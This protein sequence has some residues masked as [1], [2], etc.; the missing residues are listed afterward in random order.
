[1]R[2]T[3]RQTS[4]SAPTGRPGCTAGA[5]RRSSRPGCGKSRTRRNGSLRRRSK[6]H[7]ATT[8]NTQLH[9]SQ[10]HNSQLHNSQHPTPQLHNSQL[11]NSTTPNATTPKTRIIRGVWRW[12]AALAVAT[13]S[14]VAQQPSY[15]L[16]ILN[17]RVVDPETGLDAVRNVGIT[18]GRIAAVSPDAL[19][20][21]ATIDA[22]G[23]VVA[24]GFIDLHSH[25]NDEATFTLAA[26]D[27]VTT[28]LELEIGVPD[29]A[30]FYAARRGKARI[31]FGTSASHPWARAAAFGDA[32][33]AGAMVPPNGRAMETVAGPGER[34]EIVRRIEH[35]LDS[36]ALG[37][38]MGLA[39]TPA[40]LARK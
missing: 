1:M 37:V 11:H 33:P 29:V 28:A 30:A 20:G 2:P 27:G 6:L 19:A 39:Y 16:V 13:I 14:V 26:Q 18:G 25:I 12:L 22:R 36:G 32:P 21:R 8:P 24:P 7:S 10:L 40:P 5:S 38:G 35:E 9:N 34:R 15:D 4:S 3:R 23:L 17:G 31:N